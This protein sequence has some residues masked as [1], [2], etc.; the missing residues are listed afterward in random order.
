[1]KNPYT[2]LSITISIILFIFRFFAVS[3]LAFL[4]LSPT[5]KTKKKLLEKPIVIVA[6]DNSKS[7]LM[8]KDSL[9]Y[10]D[11]LSSNIN[12]LI[13]NIQTNY[14][15][16][17]Y[18][19]GEK[20]SESNTPDYSENTSNYSE[21][22]FYV[23]N[24]YAGLNLGAIVLVGD[25][26]VNNGIDPVYAASNINCPIYTVALGDTLQ[27]KDVKIDD[28]RYNSIVYSG[29]IFPV[30]VSISA[31]K[32]KGK[33]T[34]IKLIKNN[35]TIAK[36]SINIT[37]NSF[38]KTVTF[39]VNASNVGKN[40]YTVVI[41]PIG[42]EVSSQNNYK[43]IFIDVL[44]SRQKIL[45]L[46]YAPHPDIGAIKQGL[47]NNNN[48]IVETEIVTTR[49]T[50]DVKKYDLV[51]LH[52][53][54]SKNNS[55]IK[56]LKE[57][58]E[59]EIPV[60]YITGSQTNFTIFN[61]FFVGSNL[62]SSVGST[63]AAQFEYNSLFTY[64]SF[65]NEYKNQLAKLPPL[66]VALGNYNV[67]PNSEVFAWQVVNNVLTNYPLVV[68]NNNL[69]LKSGVIYGEGLWL[70]RI[71]NN[72]LFDNTRA[73][74]V[75]LNKIA[76]FLIA[77]TDRRLFKVNSKAEYDNHNDVIINAEL[78][79]K[80]LELNN[81]QDVSFTLTNESG[82]LFN[83]HFSPFNDYYKLNLNKLPVGIYSYK[84]NVKVGT[85]NYTDNGEFIVQQTDN[86][87]KN[88][89]ANHRLLSKLSNENNGKLY[90]PNQINQVLLDINNSEN[91]SSTIHYEDKYIGLNQIVYIFIGII[92]L[93][94]IEWFLRKYFGDYWDWK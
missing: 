12:G 8:T 72:L 71:H 9:Y 61:R 42:D 1:M 13:T 22:F 7:I 58:T 77:D 27:L 40:R 89:T 11:T 35:K 53:L 91:M 32:L 24:N 54:P 93:L 19:F 55:S 21:L 66:Q 45:I 57:L 82:E 30:E 41:E 2:K 37:N 84:A 25:G 63:V 44:N 38:R 81:T 52:Q 15:V 17:S 28:I 65:N 26:I 33:K 80:T 74:D 5:I 20:L 69:G 47:S 18:L 79:N 43:N 87:S 70:W 23:K 48:Y 76:M 46:A 3:I 83:Y 62:V 94:S 4:L 92:L 29:D 10:L 67:S 36:K 16:D 60:L 85:D 86:E 88:L 39:N 14:D 59:N 64:F 68:L 56:L 31:N 90:Y 78:Y 50:G 6:Q 75:F 49:Y 51:V 73:F 34:T